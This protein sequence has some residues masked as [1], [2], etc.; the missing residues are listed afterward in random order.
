[1]PSP[2]RRTLLRALGAAAV[3]GV[4]GCTGRQ[5]DDGLASLRPHVHRRDA[6]V[7]DFAG[8]WPTVGGDEA[9]SGANTNASAPSEDARARAVTS[10][11]RFSRSQPAVVGDRAYLGVDRRSTEIRPDTEFS[12]LVAVDLACVSAPSACEDGERDGNSGRGGDRERRLDPALWRVSAGEPT[13]SFTPTV[14]GRV[15]YARVGDSVRALDARDGSLYWRNRAGSFTPAVAGEDCY[16]VGDGVVALDVV[17]GERRWTGESLVAAPSGLAVADDAVA[18]ACGDGGEG[19]LY[20]VERADGA[21][22]WRYDAVGESYA[23]AVTD[24]ERAYAVGT[25]GVLHAVALESGERAWTYVLGGRTYERPAVA[26]GT[27]YAVGTNSERVAALDAA[28]GAVQWERRIGVGGSSA[29]VATRDAVVY[30][31]AT[32]EGE[33]LL[34]LDRADG[35]VLRR[36]E[37]PRADLGG[38]QPVVADG[39]AY[40]VG[41]AREGTQDW[42]YAVG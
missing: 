13:I 2:S 33:R 9:R 7:G 16:T 5:L 8:P 29:P 17:T 37:V 22:R 21:T 40:V 1:M 28:T 24:G 19:A 34:V 32:R 12:G 38:V 41:A 20:C 18:L 23:S 14:R 31:T 4:A 3:A 10:T 42:V 26:D 35:R 15:V 6:P 39:V 11:G 36:F 27:V 25:D 30:V